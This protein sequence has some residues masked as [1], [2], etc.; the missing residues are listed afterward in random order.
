MRNKASIL[1]QL[2]E[3]KQEPD[4][5]KALSQLADI[6]YEIGTGQCKDIK[7][8][9]QEVEG[10]RKIISGNGSPSQSLVR[11]IESIEENMPNCITR[12]SN[13]DSEIKDI[14]AKLFGGLG[15]KDPSLLHRI[16]N[17]EEY[18]KYSKKIALYI[19]FAIIGFIITQLLTSIL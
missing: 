5:Q 15:E 19:L 3:I 4:A 14:K 7:E 10:L 16:T 11:R 6:T 17:V 9:R 18:T 8:V 13:M 2:K 1:R 12:M